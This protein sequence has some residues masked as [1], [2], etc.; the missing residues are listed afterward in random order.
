MNGIID[1]IMCIFWHIQALFS[2]E[3]WRYLI[4]GQIK[5][6]RKNYPKKPDWVRSPSHLWCRL[7]GHKAGP[8]WFNPG[9]TE[10]NMHCRNCGDD[11]G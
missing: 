8:V 10:P 5:I 9:G 3:F 2:V 4:K 6:C 1:K 11:I 7:T